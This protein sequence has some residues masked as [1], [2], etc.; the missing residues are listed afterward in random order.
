MD[1]QNSYR[2]YIRTPYLVLITTANTMFP[3]K[4]RASTM[5]GNPARYTIARAMQVVT[6]TN[7]TSIFCQMHVGSNGIGQVL[8]FAM[9]E[10][11]RP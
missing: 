8:R 11:P 9:V 1:P 3:R 5:I 7:L 4:Q 6:V 2:P 10:H